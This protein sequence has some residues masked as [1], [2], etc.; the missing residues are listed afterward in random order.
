MAAEPL[1]PSV[2]LFLRPFCCSP[3]WPSVLS[4]GLPGWRQPTRLPV[5]SVRE[6]LARMR[7]R[8]SD[9]KYEQVPGE[10]IR[11]T[12]LCSDKNRGK[13]FWKKKSGEIV[14][15]V[16]PFCSDFSKFSARSS[17]FLTEWGS[18]ARMPHDPQPVCF[19]KPQKV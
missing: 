5:A 18:P 19:F 17:K 2:P 3:L 10:Q 15:K 12:K 13:F 1:L 9:G 11:M 6:A 4:G 16:G 7:R 14:K 8:G